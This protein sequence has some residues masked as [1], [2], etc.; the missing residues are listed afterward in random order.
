IRTVYFQGHPEYDAVSLL[1]EFKR[2]VNRYSDGD[3]DELPPYPDNY[4]LPPAALLA[5]DHLDRAHR[6]RHAGRPAPEFPEAQMTAWLDNT[7]RDTGKAIFNNWLGM[8]YRLT[9]VNRGV[10]FMAH[11]DPDDPMASLG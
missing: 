8:V 7:W 4:L 11:V 2:E 5:R 6:A 3:L 10:P 1:K 9:D